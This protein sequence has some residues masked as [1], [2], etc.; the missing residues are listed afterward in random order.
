MAVGPLARWRRMPLPE[1]WT[2][3]RWALLCAL[4]LGLVLPFAGGRWSPL[5]ALGLGL[6]CW[7]LLGLAVALRRRLA[8]APIGGWRALAQ[9]SPA[10]WGMV[11]A[12][13]GVAVFVFGVTVVRGYQT[14]TELR[15]PPGSSVAVG[16]H[17]LRFEGVSPVSGPNYQAERGR[18]VLSRHGQPV[19]ML[20]PEKRRYLSLPATPMTE[21]AID[22][23]WFG[24]VYV[25]L[26]EAAADGAWS[27]RVQ[28]KPFVNWIWGG[29]ALMALG[30]VIAALDRR[31]RMRPAPDSP[32]QR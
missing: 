14:E 20:Q 24:D 28:H 32:L 25:S 13:L 7:V 9:P 23:G 11:L 15:M 26:G 30:G 4:L 29:C 1:L 17:L 19:A 6:G 2:Q 3:L 5:L 22:S 18:F 31:Y 27:V 12:H 8:S 21:A 16:R 10:W